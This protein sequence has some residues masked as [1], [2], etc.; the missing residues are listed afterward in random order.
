MVRARKK[1][2]DVMETY[3]DDSD[4]NVMFFFLIVTVRVG[5]ALL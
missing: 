2:P 1:T 3:K 4:S 5:C